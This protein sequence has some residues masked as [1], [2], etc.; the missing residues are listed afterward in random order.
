MY[1]GRHLL[2]LAAL[3]ALIPTLQPANLRAQTAHVDTRSAP[4]PRRLPIQETQKE[5]MNAWTVGLAGGPVVVPYH[6]CC[7][8]FPRTVTSL[9]ASPSVVV[10]PRTAVF[11]SAD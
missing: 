1:S 4:S 7:S 10:Q 8:R 9:F 2:L 11:R 5:K 6:A 3:T